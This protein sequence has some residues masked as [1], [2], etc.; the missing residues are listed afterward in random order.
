M[1]NPLKPLGLGVGA[2]VA[3]TA[4]F[5]GIMHLAF[6]TSLIDGNPRAGDAPATPATTA[7]TA[8]PGSPPPPAPD[9]SAAQA[10]PAAPR[11]RTGTDFVVAKARWET[12]LDQ[13]G[14]AANGEKI[15][16]AGSATGAAACVTCHG[17]QAATAASS[18]PRLAGLSAEYI[19]K[20]LTDYK[21]GTR[22]HPIMSGIAKTLS[23]ADI[24]SVAKYYG[25]QPAPA[26]QAAAAA[27]QPSAGAR[28]HTGG[29]MERALP[30][31]ANCHGMDAR[32]AGPLMPGLFVQ[33]SA[34]IAAQ[35]NA[36]RGNQR[37]NDDQGE[38][39]SFAS[40]L[41]DSDIA[42]LADYYGLRP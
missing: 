33:P 42:S 10:R 9:P 22:A 35:L 1:S 29:D 14:E 20:Q 17:A 3:A 12:V 37:A 21:D 18:F 6:S 15:A 41:S 27:D 2:A 8:P 39:R 38:M 32:G 16:S 30:A 24:A 26:V 28:L 7:A 4:V 36:F 40:R 34:Y 11:E 13:G 5:V 31:C 25:L 23:E 19:A